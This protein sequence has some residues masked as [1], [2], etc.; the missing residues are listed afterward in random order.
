MLSSALIAY[1]HYL[2][3]FGVIAA[4][5][6]EAFTLRKDLSARDRRILGKAD[7]VY[8]IA[9]ILVLITGFTRVYFLG[10]GPEYYFSNTIFLTKL[11]LFIVVGI[12][13]AYPTVVFL[14]WRKIGSDIITL[15]SKQYLLI[16]RLIYLE[17]ILVLILPL[18]AAMM[19]RGMGV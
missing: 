15:E 4:L 9:A 18:L 16:R 10:K 14:K 13:S 12:L 5:T 8:G 6:V 11:G 19:A 7:T 2:S 17:I 1:V 3:V